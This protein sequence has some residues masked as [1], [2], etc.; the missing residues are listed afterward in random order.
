MK[1]N[2]LKG[3]MAMALMAMSLPMQADGVK[4]LEK[5]LDAE[6][7]K[8]EAKNATALSFNAGDKSITVSGEN[9]AAQRV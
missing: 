7:L 1:K 3:V 4:W 2:L 8:M 5:C 9:L 6:H